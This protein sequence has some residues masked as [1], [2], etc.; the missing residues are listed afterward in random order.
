M[1]KRRLSK[2]QLRRIRTQQ[3]Q[4]SDASND[5][6]PVD[7]EQT[8]E[9]GAEQE[10]IVVCHYGRQLDI[11]STEKPGFVVRCHQRSNLP[12][13]VTGDHVVW[14]PENEHSGVIVALKP[15][16]TE[17]LRPG[18]RGQLR[19]V[20][21]NIDT[22]MIVIAPVPRPHA[23]L[24]D[25][26][27]VAIE[28]LGLQPVLLLNKADL[29]DTQVPD[30]ADREALQ[31]LIRQYAG[32]GYTV[33]ET[34]CETDLNL[35]PLTVLLRKRTSIFVGQSGVGKSSLINRLLARDDSA[36]KAAAVGA[37]STARGKGTHTTTATRLYHLPDGGDLIDSPGIREFGLWQLD[38]GE[39]LEGFIEFR[40]YLGLCRFRDCSHRHEPGCA[41]QA[42][43][44]AGEVSAD[45]LDSYFHI[46][47]D[48]PD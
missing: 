9:L 48:S 12:P 29:M 6:R 18:A 41:L 37:L 25:R 1:A 21:A 19:P 10:G 17:L 20:A 40:P 38:A 13:L 27:L 42:A 15:R 44:E 30:Q 7:R 31:A 33:L 14:Q 32:I 8:D 11:E 26:Y 4:R 2:Q 36:D 24:I 35:E 5:E 39:V 34:S 23:N 47:S 43:I 16:R 46:I 22:V 28:H 3:E 45:R